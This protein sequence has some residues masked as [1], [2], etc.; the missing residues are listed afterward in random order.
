MRHTVV[1]FAVLAAGCGQ[2]VPTATPNGPPIDYAGWPALTAEPVRVPEN[3][4]TYCRRHPEEE[5]RGPHFVPAVRYYAN[6]SGYAAVAETTGPVPVG[7]TVV[8]E[9]FRKDDE[10]ASAV[11]AMVKRE[12]GYDPEFGDWEYVYS[13][14]TDDGTWAT[15][16]GK[17]DNCRA[18][19]HGAK[20]T[21]Y[22]FRTYRKK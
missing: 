7:T 18:C 8:K 16:R 14:R 21:D 5:R 17:L 4:F 13:R 19:H 3:L 11:A 2:H 9:K 22:L 12:A 10:P 20:E 15:E 6:P 1:A